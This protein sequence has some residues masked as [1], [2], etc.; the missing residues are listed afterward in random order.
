MQGHRVGPREELVGPDELGPERA[1][2]LG[3]EG[4]ALCVK[5]MHAEASRAARHRLADPSE[6]DDAEGHP[7]DAR[8]EEEARGPAA[9][10]A[11]PEESVPFDD[12]ARRSEEERE[13]QIGRR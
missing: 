11:A 2:Q 13:G 8:A 6:A 12:P 3:G 9:E 1:R 7:E 5:Y 10:A 4:R